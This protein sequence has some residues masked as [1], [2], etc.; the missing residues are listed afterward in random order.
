MVI[1]WGSE[2]EIETRSKFD[3][4]VSCPPFLGRFHLTGR[5]SLVVRSHVYIPIGP[6]LVIFL[7]RSHVI[8]SLACRCQLLLVD[9]YVVWVVKLARWRG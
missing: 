4:F 7:L 5:R 2:N 9:S 3:Q 6:A 8:T 1:P